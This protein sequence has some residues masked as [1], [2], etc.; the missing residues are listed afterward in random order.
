MA[1]RKTAPNDAEVKESS[2]WGV[3]SW[4][5]GNGYPDWNS[6]KPYQKKWEFLR[7]T[8][9]YRRDWE[10]AEQTTILTSV[11][12][13]N[14]FSRPFD[15]KSLAGKYGISHPVSPRQS[16][17]EL[18]DRFKFIEQSTY[19]GEIIYPRPQYYRALIAKKGKQKLTQHEELALNAEKDCLRTLT[20][21]KDWYNLQAWGEFD[22]SKDLDVQLA[23]AKA[24]LLNARKEAK[25]FMGSLHA[26]K[27]KPNSYGYAPLDVNESQRA[28][29]GTNKELKGPERIHPDIILLRVF[30]A[31]NCGRTNERIAAELSLLIGKKIAASTVSKQ[32][33]IAA[34]YW[35][36][37][38]R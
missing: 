27:D 13:H 10:R 30:D 23:V 34:T 29:R 28:S 21:P 35:K 14:K 37:I 7:R 8:Q 11:K 1:N 24:N 18:P 3:P 22:F 2:T 33:T 6:L 25:S 19:G 26:L 32:H 38:S 9:E 4:K 12:P 5:S 15:K 16:Y 31:K 20:P 36:R 17:N